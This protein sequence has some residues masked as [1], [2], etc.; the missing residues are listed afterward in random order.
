MNGETKC[1]KNDEIVHFFAHESDI[2][3]I[4]QKFKHDYEGKKI[5]DKK[6]SPQ[7]SLAKHPIGVR[8]TRIILSLASFE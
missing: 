6:I 8:Q 7:G 4:S 2:F 5:E 1:E 3:H